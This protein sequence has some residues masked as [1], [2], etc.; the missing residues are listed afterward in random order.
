MKN[1]IVTTKNNNF[2]LIKDCTHNKQER[3]FMHFYGL[4]NE[5]TAVFSV[6][7]IESVIE[8]SSRIGLWCEFEQLINLSS[9][10][11]EKEEEEEEE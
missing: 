5:E 9:T 6:N 3:E 10:L 4:N 8:H 7:E 2:Y 1:Y 11:S